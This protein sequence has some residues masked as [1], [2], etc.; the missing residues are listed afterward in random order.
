MAEQKEKKMKVKFTNIEFPGGD[1]KFNHGND[2][3]LYHL[4][5]GEEYDLPEAT[6][7]HLNNLQVPEARWEEVPE[8]GQMISKSFLRNRFV[9]IPV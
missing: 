8:T 6:V 2:K 3:T 9:C 5:D 7:K 1:L 4:F